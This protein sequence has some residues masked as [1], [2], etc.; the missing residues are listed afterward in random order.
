VAARTT[1]AARRCGRRA[2][3]TPGAPRP[4]TG[5]SWTR[6]RCGGTDDGGAADNGC[7]V[8]A[9]TT[10]TADSGSSAADDGSADDGGDLAA[11]AL[12]FLWGEVFFLRNVVTWGRHNHES[13]FLRSKLVLFSLF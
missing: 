12:F 13:G 1:G 7:N 11:R 8:A 5:A 3:R 4:T 9:W 6:R 2:P 10:E